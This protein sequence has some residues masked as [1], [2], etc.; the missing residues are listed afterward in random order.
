MRRE[1]KERKDCSRRAGEWVLQVKG[2]SDCWGTG[3]RGMG[4][5]EGEKLRG[6]KEMI[7][8]ALISGF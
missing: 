8:G 2:T 5:K 4:E 3:G 7:A 6:A 1:D